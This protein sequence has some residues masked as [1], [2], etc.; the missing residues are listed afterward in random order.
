MLDVG[1]VT[2]WVV[3]L[4]ADGGALV[5]DGAVPPEAGWSQGTPNV[6]EFV[7]YLVVKQT[8]ALTTSAGV[9]SLCDSTPVSLPIPYQ[10]VAYQMTRTGADELAA[11]AR[12]L[13]HQ[14]TDRHDC[15]DLQVNADRIL[16][17]A[18]QGGT[19]D[20]STSPKFWLS[21]TNFTVNVARV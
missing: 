2:T 18:V 15:G 1:E 17:T 6:G 16:I 12:T 21:T 4:L 7:E 14:A 20:D 13:L 10:V 9:A 19:R 3:S 5:G 11:S 8:P